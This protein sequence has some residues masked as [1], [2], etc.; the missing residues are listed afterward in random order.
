[1]VS[2][3][4]AGLGKQSAN[5][6][7][8]CGRFGSV[9]IRTYP[10]PSVQHAGIQKAP[11]FGGGFVFQIFNRLP[12][13]DFALSG[14]RISPDFAIPGYGHTSQVVTP[15]KRR[16][17]DGSHA[18]A[19]GHTSQ[20]VTP[21]KR[22]IPDGSH[23]VGDGHTLQVGTVLKRPIPDGCHAVGNVHT[24]QVFTPRKRLIPDGCHAVANGHSLQ[25]F[26]PPKRIYLDGSHAVWDGHTSQ[27]GTP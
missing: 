22:P 21:P 27:V 9:F 12:A 18:V 7:M 3:F 26:T 19:N 25:V 20:V 11:R 16:F 8:F 10:Y 4:A 15:P 23:A 17:P 6:W 24:S 2:L 14:K 5:G 13:G 1:M